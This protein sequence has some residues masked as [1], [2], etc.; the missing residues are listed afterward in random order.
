MYFFIIINVFFHILTR[1]SE[2]VVFD[3]L[4]SGVVAYINSAKATFGPAE[5]IF[6][7]TFAQFVHC[8]DILVQ[9]LDQ[10]QITGQQYEQLAYKFVAETQSKCGAK[11]PEAL[12]KIATRYIG[13]NFSTLHLANIIRIYASTIA[14]FMYSEGI[15]FE[16]N[17]L[18]LAIAL[19]TAIERNSKRNMN[20]QTQCKFYPINNGSV[21]FLDSYVEMSPEKG[22]KL[23]VIYGYE[24]L[25]EALEHGPGNF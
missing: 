21:N 7:K 16:K 17:A 6:L 3:S 18:E 10:S 12:A 4:D 9:L 20:C 8:S 13:L 25:L 23:A 15:L 24:F 22:E 1:F 14:R 19:A 5:K 11:Q 2:A